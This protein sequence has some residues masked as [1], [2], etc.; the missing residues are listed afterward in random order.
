MNIN[1]GVEIDMNM[2]MNADIN[3]NI[4]NSS[5]VINFNN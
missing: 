3:T 2:G 1:T 5:G 4:N